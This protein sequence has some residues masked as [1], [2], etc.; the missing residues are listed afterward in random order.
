MNDISTDPD[1]LTA[2]L[3]E[4]NKELQDAIEALDRTANV[5]TKVSSAIDKVVEVAGKVT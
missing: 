2:A 5:I 4:A 1:G 3:A